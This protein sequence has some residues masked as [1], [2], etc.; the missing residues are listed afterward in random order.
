MEMNNI[1]TEVLFLNSIFHR[2]ENTILDMTYQAKWAIDQS[3]KTFAV[4]KVKTI[5]KIHVDLYFM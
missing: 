4:Q 1:T 3:T 2:T 5:F